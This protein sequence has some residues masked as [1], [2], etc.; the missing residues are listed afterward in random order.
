MNKEELNNKGNA[1]APYISPNAKVVVINVQRV[2]CQSIPN[3]PEQ[4]GNDTW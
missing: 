1:Q 2:L 3:G 4:Y